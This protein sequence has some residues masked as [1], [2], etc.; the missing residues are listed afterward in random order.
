MNRIREI[1][2]SE[3]RVFEAK[4]EKAPE[5]QHIFILIARSYRVIITEAGSSHEAWGSS[6]IKTNKHEV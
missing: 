4:I 2:D 3:A 6:Q 1:I 5:D